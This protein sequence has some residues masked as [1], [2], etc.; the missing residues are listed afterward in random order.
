MVVVTRGSWESQGCAGAPRGATPDTM[1]YEQRISV[2][3]LKSSGNPD[4][5]MKARLC[6]VPRGVNLFYQICMDS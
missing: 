1:E 4:E 6:P 2:G 5:A 3:I